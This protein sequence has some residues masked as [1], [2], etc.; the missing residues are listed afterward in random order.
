MSSSVTSKT[1]L[2]MSS[3][4]TPTMMAASARRKS[5]GFL[6]MNIS[7]PK[8]VSFSAE[9]GKYLLFGHAKTDC[10]GGGRLKSA[11]LKEKLARGITLGFFNSSNQARVLARSLR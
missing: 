5:K 2:M 1:I 10:V 11:C 7:N 8:G 3:I 4:L 9:Q 6:H